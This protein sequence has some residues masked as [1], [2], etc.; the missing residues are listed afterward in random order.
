MIQ[1]CDL[2]QKGTFDYDDDVFTIKWEKLKRKQPI[3]LSDP[4][5]SIYLKY[6]GPSSG[7]KEIYVEIPKGCV[8]ISKMFSGIKWGNCILHVKLND[9]KYADGLFKDCLFTKGFSLG[10]SFNTSNLITFNEMFENTIFNEDFYF[11]EDFIIPDACFVKENLIKGST[12]RGMFNH[13]I[14]PEHTYIKGVDRIIKDVFPDVFNGLKVY[15]RKSGEVYL[16]TKF[17]GDEDPEEDWNPL[18]PKYLGTSYKYCTNV[19]EFLLDL[20]KK[21]GYIP[22]SGVYTCDETFKMLYM[23]TGRTLNEVITAMRHDNLFEYKD[24][25]KVA[26]R[27]LGDLTWDLD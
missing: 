27:I 6:I 11:P 1:H 13:A 14:I 16:S 17:G 26:I 20:K 8:D 23:G 2:G 9:A 12:L 5:Y 21:F 15:D 4:I 22:K 19:E 7:Y 24:I 10:S 25:I 3:K 18:V